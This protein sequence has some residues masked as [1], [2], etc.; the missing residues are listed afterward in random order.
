M[1]SMDSPITR[2]LRHLP[3]F[4][5]RCTLGYNSVAHRRRTGP[6]NSTLPRTNIPLSETPLFS[7]RQLAHLILPL[8]IERMLDVSV[9]LADTIMIASVGEA[10]VSSVALVDSINHLF[11]F[12]FSALAAGGAVVVAQYIGQRNAQRAGEAAK[13]L[14]YT[15]TFVALVFMITFL[16]FNHA[17]LYLLY[18]EID[19]QIMQ[20]A[21]LY[22]TLTALSYPF[23]GLF[24]SGAAL[25]R[26]MGNSHVSMRV[27]VIMTVSNILGNAMLIYGFGL[28]VLGAGL[29]T[30][31]S[32]IL[33]AII[34]LMLL[35]RRSEGI[36][37]DRL[38][39]VRLDWS[40]IRRILRI[41]IPN[42]I[43]SGIFHIGKILVQTLTASFGTTAIAANAIA[44]S[45]ASITNIPGG[46]IGLATITVVGQCMGA[47]RTKQADQYARKL[48]KV[49]YITLALLAAVLFLATSSMVSLFNLS[50]QSSV[51]AISILRILFV[52]NAL[53]WPLAF[54]LPQVLRAAG[55]VR[56]TM[57]VSIASMWI[58]RVGLSYIF[59]LTLGMGLHG[60]WFAMYV[61][62]LFRSICFVTRF[63]K[64]SWQ[65]RK[66]I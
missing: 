14:I 6:R 11:L 9:G 5:K 7:N 12:L 40:M 20:K 4:V 37:L 56:F 36:V 66:V 42:G 61:D 10:A 51:L 62:W 32:R 52:A 2:G 18:G 49:A 38:L 26:S 41:G 13:Q 46:A 55:D 15:T 28:G 30:L 34:M 31:A 16:L 44:N 25:F 54:T 57:S 63:L 65:T 8:V 17:I 1:S 35:V 50:E 19:A 53:I 29:A 22:F 24:N 23:L 58:F 47:G 45:I 21:Q 33:A 59:A 64:G 48:M 27:S 43:E 3:E 39:R 60:I